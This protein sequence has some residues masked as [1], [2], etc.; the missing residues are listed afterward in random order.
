MHNLLFFPELI[1]IGLK[2]LIFK[3]CTCFRDS[4]GENDIYMQYALL[5]QLVCCYSKAICKGGATILTFKSGNV[6]HVRYV[7][8]K[9][10]NKIKKR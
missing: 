8:S 10:L 5:W 2:Y 7:I 3:C 4:T 9:T 6:S 1:T